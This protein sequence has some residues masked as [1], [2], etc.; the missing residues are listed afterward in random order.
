MAPLCRVTAPFT[1]PPSDPVALAPAIAP[2]TPPQRGVTS[3]SVQRPTPNKCVPL[4]KHHTSASVESPDVRVTVATGVTVAILR[5][6]QWTAG[7]IP[8][9]RQN[10]YSSSCVPRQSV[11]HLNILRGSLLNYKHCLGLLRPK[12]PWQPVSHRM[13]V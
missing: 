5:D 9:Y 6:W 2:V 3:S 1:P 12:S 11:R 4:L 10:S 13:W 7:F 8:L